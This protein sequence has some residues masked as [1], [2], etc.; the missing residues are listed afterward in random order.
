VVV[1]RFGT[2]PDKKNCGSS[3]ESELMED[4]LY[5]ANLFALVSTR[6]RVVPARARFLVVH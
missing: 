5:Y 6:G 2:E 4:A 3:G 1:R